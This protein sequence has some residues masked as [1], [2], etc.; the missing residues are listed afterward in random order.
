MRGSIAWPE[1]KK[2]GFA[3]M[4]GLDL[5]TGHVIIFEQFRF[6]TVPHWFN[7]DGT[8]HKRDDR[9]GWHVGLVQ[10][11]AGSSSLY[12]CSS[13]FYGGQHVDVNMR[14]AREVYGNPQV[15]AR[16]ELIEVP[17]VAETGP[18]LLHEKLKTHKFKG[19]TDSILNQSVVQFV[20]MQAAQVD[21][22]NAVLALM[23]LLAGFD[24][25]PWV[26]I[27]N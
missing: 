23:A 6:W 7:D 15:P 11:I 24:F 13:Y 9:T 2:E 27:N 18:D 26:K 19:D 16:L 17:Y 21:Y 5:E 25:Q 10:F 12:Q 20:N 4:A 3:I 14:Y 1:G 22:D 8:I